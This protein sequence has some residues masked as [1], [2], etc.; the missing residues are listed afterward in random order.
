MQSFSRATVSFNRIEATV[1][2]I[3]ECVC[4]LTGLLVHVWDW[5]LVVHLYI[6]EA[7]MAHPE[8]EMERAPTSKTRGVIFIFLVSLMSATVKLPFQL[9]S[10]LQVEGKA[11]D[12]SSSSPASSSPAS[13]SPASS[14]PASATS[15]RTRILMSWM[16]SQT[17]V[18]VISVAAGIPIIYT[19][20]WV[21]EYAGPWYWV[22]N[23]FFLA[24]LSVTI[25]DLYSTVVA[26]FFD[27]YE[28]LPPGS[29]RDALE[30]LTR[31]SNCP[32]SEIYIRKA[33]DD[34]RGAHSNAFFMGVGTSRSIVL[35]ES[36][37]G[38]MSESEVLAII[39]HEISHVKKNHFWKL[40]FAE[41]VTIG[42]FFVSFNVLVR[43]PS[44]YHAFGFESQHAAIGLVLFSYM[45][46]PVASA[47]RSVQNILSRSFE[48]TAD[49]Y[50]TKLGFDLDVPLIKLHGLNLVNIHADTMYSIY[51]Y[52]HPSL[53]ER[54]EALSLLRNKL[55]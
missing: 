50:A 35:Y 10:T 54:L 42:A 22:L 6:L 53:C 13:A 14:S 30:E 48:F 36:L 23:W 2:F 46:T 47:L 4:L 27:T 24:L 41:F 21:L 37:L 8:E 19:L 11:S 26:P 40:V 28:S 45:Y 49:A 15:S 9:Y 5:A 55:K 16:W 3:L 43:S 52:S 1:G 44:F 34:I 38:R 18:F 20:L 31:T 17:L 33:A 7:S 25:S 32:V 51:H 29:L 39:A 12:A